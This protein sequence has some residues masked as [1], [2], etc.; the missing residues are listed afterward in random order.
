MQGPQQVEIWCSTGTANSSN[1]FTLNPSGLT[2]PV[3][4]HA[5][6]IVTTNAQGIWGNVSSLPWT[7]TTGVNI[8]VYVSVAS[9]VSIRSDTGILMGTLN[10]AGNGTVALKPAWYMTGTASG[11]YVSQ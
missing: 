1:C 2:L 5:P 3:V 6:S 4:L 10:T 9:A 7:N 11:T 8:M